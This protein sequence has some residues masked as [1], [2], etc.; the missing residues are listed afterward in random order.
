[1][2]DGAKMQFFHRIASGTPPDFF[3]AGAAKSIT[4]VERP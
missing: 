4:H 2:R 1:M 3:W